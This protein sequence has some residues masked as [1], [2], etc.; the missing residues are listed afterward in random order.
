MKN[1][2]KQLKNPNILDVKFGHFTKSLY[3]AL[4]QKEV[5]IASKWPSIPL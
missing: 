5:N 1:K 3:R 4:L 2:I